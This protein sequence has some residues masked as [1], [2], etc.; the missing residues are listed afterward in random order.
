MHLET[1][2]KDMD[3]KHKA[4]MLNLFTPSFY[5]L[6]PC[7]ADLILFWQNFFCLHVA[8]LS[9]HISWR[10]PVHK[11]LSVSYPLVR[12]SSV[13]LRLCPHQHTSGHFLILEE[14][15]IFY[16]VALQKFWDSA[17]LIFHPQLFV[18]TQIRRHHC[19][20]WFPC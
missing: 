16:S 14:T 10:K 2:T 1:L 20:Q 13:T 6:S 7:P 19:P 15:L 11:P 5:F 8:Y 9:G 17:V 18:C 12:E 4:K 3:K